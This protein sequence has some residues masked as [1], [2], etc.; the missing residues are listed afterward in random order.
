MKTC[1]V[2]PFRLLLTIFVPVA[3]LSTFTF[4]LVNLADAQANIASQAFKPSPVNGVPSY[5]FTKQDTLFIDADDNHFASPGDIIQYTL[6]FTNTS[7]DALANLHFTDTVDANTTLVGGSLVVSPFA[8]A[9]EATAVIN[10]PL[11]IPTP[12]L[13]AN[14]DLQGPGTTIAAY[15][16][17]TTQGG[18]VIIHPDGGFSYQPPTNFVGDDS[19]SYTLANDAGSD[20][21]VVQLT[22]LNSDLAVGKW[23]NNSTPFAEGSI[24]YT[25]RITNEGDIPLT[26]IIISDTLPTGLTYDDHNA[27]TGSSFNP[28][29]G[30]WSVPSLGIGATADL[31]IKM[32][33][34][35]R[36]VGQTITNTA[37]LQSLDQPDTNPGNNRASATL[38]VQPKV[39][40]AINKTVDNSTPL[41]GDT[42]VYTIT[43]ANLGPNDATGVQVLD[44]L[45]NGVTFV[46]SNQASYLPPV[47]TIGHLN[48]NQTA[49]LNITATVNHVDAGSVYTNE[50]AVTAVN[51]ADSNPDNDSSRAQITIHKAPTA[52][53][54]DPGDHPAFQV[55]AGA[56][57]NQPNGPDDLVERNDDVGFPVATINSF[58]GGSL[59]GKVTDNNAGHTI[60]PL[61]AFNDGSLTVYA[62]G[63]F[64]F[65]PPTGFLGDF[66]FQYRLSNSIG[67]SDAT[68][69]IRVQ[70]GPN[71]V[72]DPDGGLP[73]SSTPGSTPY[74]LHK[75]SSNN[76]ITGLLD[77]DTLGNP[78]AAMTSFGGGSLGGSVTDYT[79]GQTAA[80]SGHSLRVN[81]DGSL[82][83]T[84]PAAFTGLFTFQYRLTN[85]LGTDDATVT[86]AVGERPSCDNDNYTA[87]GNIPINHN[88]ASGVLAN[89]ANDV[90]ITA[91]QGG[92]VGT[93]QNSDKTGRGGVTGRITLQANGRFLYDPPPGFIGEDSFAYTVNNNYDDPQTCTATI[94]V[95]DMVWFIDSSASGS[96]LGTMRDPF[97]TIA[98]FNNANTGGPFSPNT[99]SLIYLLKGDG[100]LETEGI[101][102]HDKQRLIGQRINLATVINADSASQNFPPPFGNPRTPLLQTTGGSGIDLAANNTIRGLD[103]GDTPTGFALEGTAVGSPTINQVNITG[104]GGALRINGGSLGNNVSFNTLES[105]SSPAQNVQL[106]N[107]TGSVNV[108]SGGSGLSGAAD[109]A[110]AISGGTVNF[111]YPGSI[112]QNA[113]FPTV[114]VSDGHSGSLTFGGSSATNG[115]GLQFDNADGSY[116]FNGST[117]LNGGDAGIDIENHS[118][119]S[120]AF[121][122][123]TI[124]NPSGTAFR[125]QTSNA[126]VTYSGSIADIDD[127]AVYIWNNDNSTVTFQSG[128]ITSPDRGITVRDSNHST[129]HFNNNIDLDT[130]SDDAL[131]LRNNDDSTINF[132]GK[133]NINTTTGTA[134]LADGGGTVNVTANGNVINT[135]NRGTAVFIKDT[136]IGSSNITFQTISTDKAENGI[137][138]QGTGASGTFIVTNGGTMQNSTGDGIFVQNGNISLNQMSILNSSGSGILAQLDGTDSMLINLTNNT[139]SGSVSEGIRVDVGNGSADNGRMD[140]IMDNNVIN[141]P[142]NTADGTHIQSNFQTTLC[143][144]I[145]DNQSIGNGGMADFYLG[146]QDASAF[147]LQ[148]FATDVATTLVNKSN[149]KTGGGTVVIDTIGEPFAGAMNC[150]TMPTVLGKRNGSINE[151]Q[152]GVDQTGQIPCSPPLRPCVSALNPPT[153]NNQISHT[154]NTLPPGKTV[155]LRF[156]VQINNP[157]PNGIEQISSQAFATATNMPTTPSDDPDTTDPNDPTITPIATIKFIHLPLI[158]N[159]VNNVTFLPD[160]IVEDISASSDDLFVVLKNIGAAPVTDE[161]WVDAYFNPNP[162]PTSVNQTIQTLAVDG[163]VWGVDNTAL[164]IAPGEMLTLTLNS[165]FYD[166]QNSRFNGT[167]PA[168][169]LYVQVDSANTATTYGAVLETHEATG[170]TYNNISSTSVSRLVRIPAYTATVTQ[171]LGTKRP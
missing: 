98:A 145:S 132:T 95:S 86:I 1:P 83:Y 85:T 17:A 118:D 51:E 105:T 74:H 82:T 75:G 54:D 31:T 166:T 41:A 117:T 80:N 57:L 50:A 68:V 122:N 7:A 109:T 148:D 114:A 89:D 9:D 22:V 35:E 94:H 55:S 3:I 160:L 129:I 137:L 116:T 163:I 104:T 134:F 53:D 143:A 121:N 168:G 102:L 159:N 125:I 158:I 153:N 71:A 19:F 11:T 73:G 87:T 152:S 33:V 161:F 157:F 13:L 151:N 99:G 43:A 46:S 136:T 62:N 138:L 29:T 24:A 101:N 81:S 90:Q 49:T 127:T 165:P 5:K 79:P 100:Y 135:T 106:V 140:L 162:P 97:P 59:G 12:G 56:T 124:I 156:N 66:R 4:L 72:D 91:V 77:N 84:P 63:R 44:A 18:T 141:T 78:T 2:T 131:V 21:A 120:F 170:G 155:T 126:D 167:I 30:V 171:Q 108:T 6:S 37:V 149:G 52:T 60:A 69:T 42:I 144:N 38:A 133:I 111:N 123:A 130:A 146:Q 164:P 139:I 14:D 27:P 96:N 119:G 47:W 48:A 25:V 154:I 112:S 70:E 142:V 65:T 58:G 110:V 169:A 61:P 76:V 150:N 67:S 107:V 26:N 36:T 93:T 103:I 15:D 92:S 8:F 64:T 45:P 34:N 28:A 115:T 32:T 128:A 113:D 147:F 88:A 40:I 23:V 10:T 16:S 20:T 39:D